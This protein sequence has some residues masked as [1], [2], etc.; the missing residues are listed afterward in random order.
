VGVRESTQLTVQHE[1]YPF[2]SGPQAEWKLNWG[3]PE[4]EKTW[5]PLP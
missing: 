2:L 4:K 1:G 5:K 3:K